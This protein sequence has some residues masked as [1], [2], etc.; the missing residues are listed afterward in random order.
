MKKTVEDIQNDFIDTSGEMSER[1]GLTRVAGLL[2]LGDLVGV[3]IRVRPGFLGRHRQ[4]HE[5][6][7][8]QEQAWPPHHDP[9]SFWNLI[10]CPVEAPG[11]R[12]GRPTDA[13]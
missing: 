13:G 4:R 7:G 3:G 1:Y 8:Q 12:P 6:T 5:K 11:S 10:W 2:K 9:V